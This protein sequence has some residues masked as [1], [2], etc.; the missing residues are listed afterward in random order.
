MFQKHIMVSH[1]CNIWDSVQT[2]CQS[3]INITDDCANWVQ[4]CPPRGQVKSNCKS[5]FF[6]GILLIFL[7]EFL[8]KGL[9]IWPCGCVLLPFPYNSMPSPP[10]KHNKPC[11]CRTD[12]ALCPESLLFS[13]P[14]GRANS[15]IFHSHKYHRLL[16]SLSPPTATPAFQPTVHL[17]CS[18]VTS[19]NEEQKQP[20]KKWWVGRKICV[21]LIVLLRGGSI[22]NTLGWKI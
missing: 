5:C 8:W 1:F 9:N 3:K 21:C 7:A 2:S 16:D 14:G 6:K 20:Q 15:L 17:K 10:W 13:S 19:H 18:S 12:Y 4:E 22:Q 11:L